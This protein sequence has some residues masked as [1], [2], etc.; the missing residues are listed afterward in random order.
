MPDT[1][2]VPVEAAV[3]SG[4]GQQGQGQQVKKLFRHV[5]DYSSCPTRW[6]EFEVVDDEQKALEA[7]LATVPIVHRHRLSSSGGWITTDFTINS[8]P[9]R[10][11]LAKAL[12]KYQDLDLDSAHWTFTPPYQPIVHR[13]EQLKALLKEA[14][15]SPDDA[16]DA[17]ADADAKAAA[18]QLD[19][20]LTPVL[21]D[22][23]GVLANIRETQ[24]VSHDNIWHVF[25]PGELVVTKFYG[26]DTICRVVRFTE[27]AFFAVVTV[28]YVDWN[29]ETAGLATRAV[30]VPNYVG[31]QLVR[32]L[33]VYPLSFAD[34][35]DDLKARLLLR[36]R[37]F[38]QLRGYHYLVAKPGVKVLMT[39][40]ERAA[41]GRVAI[42]AYAYYHS[43][44][45][46]KPKLRSLSHDE[47]LEPET[48]ADKDGNEDG[49][50]GDAANQDTSETSSM[51][52]VQNEMVAIS[53]PSTNIER[54]EDLTPLSD[55]DCLLATPWVIGL[56][57][58]TKDWA[59]FLID[60]LDE[61]VW[62]DA[63]Y[64][65]LVL[66]EGEKELAWDFVESKAAEKEVTDDFV[67]DKGRGIIILMFGPPGVGK[68]F[69]AEA[70][71][72]RAHVPLYSL[73]AGVLGVQ[74]SEVET[75]LNYTLDLCRMWKAML[76]LDEADVFLGARTNEGLTRNELVSI[77]LTKLEYY[78][79]ILFLTT[80]RFASIDYAFQSRV[81]LFLPYHALTPAA[82]RQVWGNF[83]DHHGR[84]RFS[85]TEAELDRLA[86]LSLNGREIKNL[87]KS[88]QLLTARSGG[89][90]TAD[91]L[92][93][94]AE[95]RVAA[96]R[97]L[98]QQADD[99]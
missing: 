15:E 2:V 34:S 81:D 6:A 4:S 3:A 31:T 65:K 51:V 14:T 83:F 67:A 46:V 53:Q 73:S 85:I 91:R 60:D 23:I 64:D 33:P 77:F 86:G 70:V 75:T 63:A 21:D 13:W 76:L 29:G 25:S 57:M 90:V 92:Y 22:S 69:T 99:E 87:I 56:D 24:R 84:H 28:E 41:S 95:K 54:N 71:A 5:C 8:P 38:E 17:D 48:N 27:K 79:G 43:Q 7:R 62:N 59:H 74:P 89:K 93:S 49:D 55:A 96:L 9:M 32:S 80:N 97:M 19:A 45:L 88:A 66:P 11:L 12:A 39:S 10:A 78:Q 16:A 72:E 30:R 26:V 94:L 82:R 52:D 35:P 58:K 37:R 42:D 47:P 44:S 40:E 61:I 98:A 20:F 18:E 1:Q 68:T 50:N 36:G